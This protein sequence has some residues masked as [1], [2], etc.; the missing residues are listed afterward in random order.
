MLYMYALAIYILHKMSKWSCHEKGTCPSYI[1]PWG[2]WVVRDADSLRGTLLRSII[3][4]EYSWWYQPGNWS[5]S[6]SD[7]GQDC[8][9]LRH[10]TRDVQ[11]QLSA[12]S[13]GV[14]VL[15]WREIYLVGG[16]SCTS[17][18]S[19]K[20]V[21]TEVTFLASGPAYSPANYLRYVLWWKCEARCLYHGKDMLFPLATDAS[22][23]I[24]L[25][26]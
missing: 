3:E 16:V 9:K 2:Q 14:L 4:Y 19:H 18:P 15:H 26:W 5:V 8:C 1:V 10:I 25:A 21:M 22:D 13:N 11:A 7:I 12:E 17:V 6:P 23:G 20:L 24:V